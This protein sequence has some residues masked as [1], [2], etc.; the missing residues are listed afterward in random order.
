MASTASPY[1]LIPLRRLGG[2]VNTGAVNRYEIANGLTSNIYTGDIVIRVATGT[3]TQ[4]T[5]TTDLI[6]GV[7]QG[8]EWIDPVTKRPTW[9]PYFPT[10]TSSAPDNTIANPIAYVCDDPWMTFKAQ[11][12]TSS[13]AGDVFALFGLTT[14]TNTS[15]STFT[16][17]SG[18]TLNVAS[19]STSSNQ[20]RVISLFQD[21]S[22]DWLQ[23]APDVEVQIV[24]HAYN[25]TAGL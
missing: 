3:I 2:G 6:L 1:G 23:A 14:G 20:F 22:N 12:N 25:T 19:R 13:S 10:G 21:P 18:E 24:M 11:M 15:G 9:S 5:T 16:G 4:A 8:C 17:I 7:F